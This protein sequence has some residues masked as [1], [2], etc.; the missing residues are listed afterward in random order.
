MKSQVPTLKPTQ[1]L[2]DEKTWQVKSQAPT[3]EP[4]QNLKGAQCESKTK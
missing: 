2:K 4:T 1:D 3:L